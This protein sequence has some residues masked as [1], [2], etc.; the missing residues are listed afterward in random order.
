[1][2]SRGLRDNEEGMA[3]KYAILG[4][5]FAI[6]WSAE[7]RLPFYEEFPGDLK[8]KLRH[9]ARNLSLGF[10]NAGITGLIEVRRAGRFRLSSIFIL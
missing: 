7:S 3:L 6:L 1:M 9:D 2:L 8:E 10:V 4:T 5:S